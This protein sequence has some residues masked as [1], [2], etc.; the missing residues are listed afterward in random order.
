M[1]HNFL[2]DNET[3]LIMEWKT[4][5][6]YNIDKSYGEDRLSQLYN[7]LKMIDLLLKCIETLEEEELDRFAFY[8]NK[9][10]TKN[11]EC[12]LGIYDE[13]DKNV[14]HW[15]RKILHYIAY[16]KTSFVMRYDFHN[17]RYEISIK[18]IKMNKMIYHINKLF[19]QRLKLYLSI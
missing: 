7:E 16:D 9:L 5:V 6:S 13:K 12:Y 19:A 18:W 10:K 14:H 4:R 3:K 2:K 11:N 8:L 15:L 17:S 1:T